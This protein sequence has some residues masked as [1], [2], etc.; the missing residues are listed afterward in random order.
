MSRMFEDLKDTLKQELR[1]LSKREMTKESLDTMYKLAESLKAVQTIEAM[2]KSESGSSSE[3]GYS[4]NQSMARG[5]YGGSYNG[6]SYD[7]YNQGGSNRGSYNRGSYNSYDGSYEGGGSNRGSYDSYDGSSNARRGRDGDGDGRYSE[8][9]YSRHSSKERM[10][11][12][13]ETMMEEASTAKERE[14]I[15]RCMEQL[16]G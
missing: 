13:L 11:Q 15:M 8:R 5:S 16:E 2:E 12:K 9:S 10:I 7:S 6:G 1:A 3:P 4:M 14:A